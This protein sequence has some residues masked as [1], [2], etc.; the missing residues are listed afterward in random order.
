MNTIAVAAISAQARSEHRHVNEP[1]KPTLHF[2]DDVSD[3]LGILT[4]YA[5]YQIRSLHFVLQVCPTLFHKVTPFDTDNSLTAIP[6]IES[7]RNIKH[8]HSIMIRNAV[9]E[10]LVLEALAH[11]IFQATMQWSRVR[12]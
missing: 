3:E 12:I 4:R 8:K 11:E 1:C 9:L 5:N 6:Q 10:A 7:V 2:A